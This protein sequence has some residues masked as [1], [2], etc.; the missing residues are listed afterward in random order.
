MGG[1]AQ[2]DIRAHATALQAKVAARLLWPHRQ[3]WKVY[4]CHAFERCML[5]VGVAALVNSLGILV[6]QPYS[7]ATS[8]T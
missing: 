8:C 1:I 2:V 3:P 4:M 5:G 7:H 6:L